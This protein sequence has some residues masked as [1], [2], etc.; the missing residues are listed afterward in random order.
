MPQFCIGLAATSIGDFGSTQDLST[1][2]GTS[3][4]ASGRRH[5]TPG[6][7]AVSLRMEV[8]NGMVQPLEILFVGL[9]EVPLVPFFINSVAPPFTRCTG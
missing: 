8:D 4:R 1:C 2:Q 5:W 3:P 6:D 7:L 9:T